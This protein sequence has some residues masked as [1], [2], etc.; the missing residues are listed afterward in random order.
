MVESGCPAT[1]SQAVDLS[2]QRE[3]PGNRTESLG[4][5]FAED[6]GI[7]AHIDAQAMIGLVI[8]EKR[9]IDTAELRIQD[10]LKSCELE[11]VEAGD[12]YN[13]ADIFTQPVPQQSLERHQPTAGCVVVPADSCP[14]KGKVQGGVAYTCPSCMAATASSLS[15]HTACA[16]LYSTEDES[17]ARWRLKC[18]S[19]W[20]LFA[21]HAQA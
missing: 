8:L 19:G 18:A 11:V 14:P 6:L 15:A 20:T 7:R 3:R 2:T 9:Q 4:Q 1:Q 21:E 17:A 10:A 12:G 16:V 5:D 13:P